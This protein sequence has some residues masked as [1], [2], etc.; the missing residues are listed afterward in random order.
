MG[1]IGDLWREVRADAKRA[2]DK[3]AKRFSNEIIL[4]LHKSED[5]IS[6]ESTEFSHIIESKK[7]GKIIVYPKAN[8]ILICRLN[9]WVKGAV[10]WLYE[11]I[12]NKQKRLNENSNL[13][14]SNDDNLPAMVDNL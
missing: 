7:Y 5:V 10:S 11:N 14:T 13:P 6:V 8:K 2:R 9:K 4:K 1:E 12:I 3:R